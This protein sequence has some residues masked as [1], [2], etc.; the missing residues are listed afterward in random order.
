MRLWSDQGRRRSPL[1]RLFE[2]RRRRGESH[3]QPNT[4]RPGRVLGDRYRLERLLACGGMAT[5][6]AATDLSERVDVALKLLH[7]ALHEDTEI[8][9]GFLAEGTIGNGIGHPGVVRALGEDVDRDGNA[10]LVLE[11]LDGENLEQLATRCGGALDLR[12]VAQVVHPLLDIIAAVHEHGVVHRDIKPSNVILTR[13]GVTKLIDFGVAYVRGGPR[14][15]RAPGPRG[16]PAYMAP[17]QVTGA[18]EADPRSDVWSVGATAFALLSGRHVHPENTPFETLLASSSRPAPLLASVV[19]SVPPSLAHVIDRALAYEPSERWPTA[20]AMR[21][22][23]A[24]AYEEA[25]GNSIAD[26]RPTCGEPAHAPCSDSAFP[27]LPASR[28][29]SGRV[30]IGSHHRIASAEAATL[31]ELAPTLRSRTG[32]S[33]LKALLLARAAS[34]RASTEHAA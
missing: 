6:Y 11:L 24:S 32:C 14:A 8:L 26:G 19:S 10:F 3:L 2:P 22:A 31:P 4:A 18:D 9:P 25:F 5:V 33:E 1:A 28:R 7:R 17:E 27:G 20:R 12:V 16:T 15:L 30:R 23:L 21:S 34:R 29:A 13:E